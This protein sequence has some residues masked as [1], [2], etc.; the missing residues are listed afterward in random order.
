MA[1]ELRWETLFSASIVDVDSFG[2]FRNDSSADLF[3]RS[4][5]LNLT[6]TNIT[7]T[8]AANETLMQLSKSNTVDIINN[9]SIFQL[10]IGGTSMNDETGGVGPNASSN[11]VNKLYAKGQLILE[12]GESVFGHL[13]F[14]NSPTNTKAQIT[15]GYHF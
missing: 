10:N 2:E 13:D 5:D 1:E 15:I 12:P 11:Q 7:A 8:T 14:T 4:I 6:V 3:I 9:S